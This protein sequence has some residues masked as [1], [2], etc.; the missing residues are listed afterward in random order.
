[1]YKRIAVPLDGSELAETALPHALE[2]ARCMGGEVYPIRVA[3]PAQYVVSPAGGAP[4]FPEEVLQQDRREAERYLEVVAARCQTEGVAAH[5]QLLIGP[6]AETVVDFAKENGMDLIV[7]STHGRSGV[8]R[9]VY[10][11]VAEKVLRG[12]HCPTLIVRR[13]S[14]A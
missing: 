3:P 4:L 8:S 14:M 7:M 9:W 10:G 5:V 11:S 13:L 2:L 12:A 6:V 1:M